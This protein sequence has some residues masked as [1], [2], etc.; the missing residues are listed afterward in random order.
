MD[1]GPEHGEA[2]DH[3]G[4]ERDELSGARARG[5]APVAREGRRT[6]QGHVGIGDPGCERSRDPDAVRVLTDADERGREA[7]VVVMAPSS[8][9]PLGERGVAAAE[10]DDADGHVLQGVVAGG[11]LGPHRARGEVRVAGG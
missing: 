11:A 1:A 10:G 7:H 2:G 3:D 6:Q 9:G 8:V 5:D 4:C